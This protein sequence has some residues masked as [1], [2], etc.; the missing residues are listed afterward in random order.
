MLVLITSHHRIIEG[1]R[2]IQI[3]EESACRRQRDGEVFRAPVRRPTSLTFGPSVLGQDR[4]KSPGR[5]NCIAR[6]PL[7]L[8][9][10]LLCVKVISLADEVTS[11]Q[12]K[13]QMSCGTHGA[14]TFRFSSHLEDARLAQLHDLLSDHRVLEV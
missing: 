4:W 7:L 11:M 8:L 10:H 2:S 13:Q 12:Q 1:V 3:E 5:V 9:P 14:Q 6:L